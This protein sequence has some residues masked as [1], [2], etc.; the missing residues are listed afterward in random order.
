MINFFDAP[1]FIYLYLFFKKLKNMQYLFNYIETTISFF[2]E[3]DSVFVPTLYILPKY[4]F[5]AL[6]TM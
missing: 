3:F 4:I 5:Y 2:K 6:K 1:K